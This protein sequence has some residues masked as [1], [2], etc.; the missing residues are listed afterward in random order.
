MHSTSYLRN[1]FADIT[2]EAAISRSS[3]K[4]KR[5]ADEPERSNKRARNAAN[6]ADSGI[7][8]NN[9]EDTE[10][11]E[12]P[13][14]NQDSRYRSYPSVYSS[15]RA[16]RMGG[17]SQRA[18]FTRRPTYTPLISLAH[19]FP[20]PTT[21][22][23]ESFVSSNMSDLFKCHSLCA[24]S[25]LTTPYAC[26]YSNG[27]YSFLLSYTMLKRLLQGSKAGRESLLAVA[28]EEGTVSLQSTHKRQDLNSG[29]PQK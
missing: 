16:L 25:F 28:T 22:V 4:G 15:L 14:A 10:M 27:K 26:A 24:D 5:R 19:S 20:V 8:G 17:P 29:M 2:N 1:P 6:T 7:S 11:E 3:V 23:L 18:R 21:R 12:L 13:S 9:V